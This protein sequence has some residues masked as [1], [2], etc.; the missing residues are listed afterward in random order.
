[1]ATEAASFGLIAI[2]GRWLECC[3]IHRWTYKEMI[4]N[5]IQHFFSGRLVFL[6]SQ[7]FSSH[8]TL[9]SLHFPLSVLLF[10]PFKLHLHSPLSNNHVGK[11]HTCGTAFKQHV[12]GSGQEGTKNQEPTDPQCNQHQLNDYSQQGNSAAFSR[13]TRKPWNHRNHG[14]I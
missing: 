12:V 11:I 10:L 4:C 6:C 8:T 7:P 1:M 5:N 13:I 3:I 9:V 2:T 14:H